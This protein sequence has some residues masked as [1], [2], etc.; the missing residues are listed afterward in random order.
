MTFIDF[1]YAN[2]LHDELPSVIVFLKKAFDA[3]RDSDTASSVYQRGYQN[4]LN[5]SKRG[6]KAETD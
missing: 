3:G 4:G 1:L 6:K 5:E 2:N